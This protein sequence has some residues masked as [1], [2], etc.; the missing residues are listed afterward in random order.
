MGKG[1]IKTRRGKIVNGSYG[2][3]RKRDKEDHHTKTTV[4]K[5]TDNKE[6][7]SSAPATS[8][9]SK[10]T[11]DKPSVQK[12][13]KEESSTIQQKKEITTAPKSDKKPTEIKPKE[14]PTET[15]TKEKPTEKPKAK[16]TPVKKE[17]S[18]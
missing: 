4:D 6:I 2:V 16:K 1:D 14:V 3:R 5:A 18:E 9:T 11:S 15:V 17:G 8:G 7:K 12:P 13:K 10:K